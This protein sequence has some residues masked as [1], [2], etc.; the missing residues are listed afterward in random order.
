MLKIRL[1]RFGRK[2]N[3]FYRIVVIEAKR[4]NKGKSLA[5]VGYWYPTKKIKKIN[6]KEIE[7][8]IALGAQPTKAVRELMQ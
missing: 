5:R 8:W 2:N 7:R 4:K 1:A 6:K 3:P